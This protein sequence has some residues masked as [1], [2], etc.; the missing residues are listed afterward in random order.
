M[1]ASSGPIGPSFGILD[2]VRN[3]NGFARLINHSCA[4]NCGVK[5]LIRIVA[6]RDI[7]PGE[8]IFWDYDMSDNAEWRMFCMCGAE[9]CRRV[10]MG[11]RYLPQEFRDR[12]RG[13]ISGYLMVQDIPVIPLPEKVLLEHPGL[14]AQV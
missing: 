14:V 12:Y 9:E 11:Y 7:A 8:E 13:Y 2:R 6:M 10:L 4:P 5:D 1:R 3:S